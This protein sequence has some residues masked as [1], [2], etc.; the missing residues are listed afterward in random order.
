MQE[1]LNRQKDLQE[2]LGQP[3]GKGVPSLKENAYALIVEVTEVINEFNWKPWRKVH[4]KVERAKV[5][6]EM[7][8]VLIFYMNMCNDLDIT[9]EELYETVKTK[10][11]KVYDRFRAEV[12]KNST[13]C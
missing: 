8:D 13:N 9:E 5:V 7:A 12:S 3:M 1:L 4:K 6:E 10:Q 2:K 11:E